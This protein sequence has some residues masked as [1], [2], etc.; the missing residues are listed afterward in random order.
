MIKMHVK[1]TLITARNTIDDAEVNT[2]NG[3]I[4]T[5]TGYVRLT[6]DTHEFVIS[7]END[8]LYRYNKSKLPHQFELAP[9]SQDGELSGDF[10]E[11]VLSNN[12]LTF[13][14]FTY[15]YTVERIDFSNNMLS[16]FYIPAVADV[17]YLDLSHNNLIVFQSLAS[18]LSKSSNRQALRELEVLYIQGNRLQ[19]LYLQHCE[20]LKS[21]IYAEMQKS[22]LS[23]EVYLPD[24]LKQ[25]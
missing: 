22:E 20:K 24:H 3:V 7:T 14:T 9:C 5:T 12:K 16:S 1:L 8:F 17:K 4:K 18:V 6:H 15:S 19:T 2:L 23:L 21:L 25:Q 13:A 10:L 11:V